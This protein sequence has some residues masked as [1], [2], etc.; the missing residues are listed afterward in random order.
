MKRPV[1][2]PAHLLA[3]AVSLALEAPAPADVT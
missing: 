2:P 1:S 3:V